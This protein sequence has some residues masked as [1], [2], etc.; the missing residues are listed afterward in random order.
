MAEATVNITDAVHEAV[1][2]MRYRLEVGDTVFDVWGG[3]HTIAKVQHFKFKTTL[4][5]EDGSKFDVVG[6]S[7]IT[8]IKRKEH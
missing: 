5:R 2:V 7:T 8:V 6:D 1:R 4:T 3:Q